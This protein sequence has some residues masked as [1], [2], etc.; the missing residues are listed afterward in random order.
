MPSGRT[1][2]ENL[3]DYRTA[4]VKSVVFWTLREL[5][6]QAVPEALVRIR[7]SSDTH[8]R[9]RFYPNA[10]RR[11]FVW[12]ERAGD[13]RLVG[14]KVPEGVRYLLMCRIPRPGVEP[15]VHDRGLRGGPP[16][17]DIEN[18]REALVCIVAHEGYHLRQLLF[19]SKRR[20]RFSEVECEWAEYRCLRRF[21]NNPIARRT[22]A[23]I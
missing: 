15:S 16:P 20:R 18:W 4:D 10:Q 17:F 5:D 13:Y 23:D 1:R 21:R 3:T 14:P 9:G 19:R 8:T 6:L 7:Y 11:E 12:S 2:V 22:F